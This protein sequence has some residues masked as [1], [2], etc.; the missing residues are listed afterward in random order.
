MLF[1]IKKRRVELGLTLEEIGRF[2]GVSKGTVCKW[3]QGFIKNMRRDKIIKLA[4]ILQVSP[5]DFLINEGFISNNTEQK[6][7]PL[8][9]EQIQIFEELMLSV[10]GISNIDN[11]VITY[12][13]NCLILSD[14]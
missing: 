7:V 8:N 6:K 3:E 9:E 1:D 12:R 13:N 2:V 5:I 14:L 10:F 4:E 11:I